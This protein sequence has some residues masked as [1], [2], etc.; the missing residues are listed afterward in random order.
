MN[1][2]L[3][4]I[5]AAVSATAFAEGTAPADSMRVETARVRSATPIYSEARV[6]HT[7]CAAPAGVTE[8]AP[9]KAGPSA[10]GIGLGA[11][12]GGLLGHTIGGGNGKT[13]ATAVGAVAGA[14]V[15]N[16]LASQSGSTRRDPAAADARDCRAVDEIRT[17]LAGYRVR[18]EW[19]GHEYETVMRDAPGKTIDVRVS[20]V[21]VDGR[22]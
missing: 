22:R 17:Q 5:L 11:V 13:A 21:P 10:M 19:S 12:A 15:G 3:P 1:K 6:P 2:L 4:V 7:E 14:L 18:Y 8:Q 16:Q 9:A 20:V